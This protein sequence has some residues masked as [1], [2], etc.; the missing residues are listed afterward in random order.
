MPSRSDSVPGATACSVRSTQ[1][2]T[3][4]DGTSSRALPSGEVSATQMTLRPSTLVGQIRTSPCPHGRNT[5]SIS[6]SRAN[7]QC[8]GASEP[9][10]KAMCTA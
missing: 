9:I 2:A 5:P 7:V 6:R 8:T 10:W 4:V 3:A 1:V